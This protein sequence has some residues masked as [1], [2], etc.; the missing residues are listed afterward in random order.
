MTRARIVIP[1]AFAAPLLAAPVLLAASAA[2]QPLDGSFR[3]MYVCQKMQASPDILRAPLDLVVHGEKVEFARPLFN[4]N[5]TR[6]VGSEMASGSVDPDGKMHLTSGWTNRGVTFQ[7]DYTGTLSP[8]GGTFTGTQN[9]H[10][11]NGISGSRTCTAAL[12]QTASAE[13]APNSAEQA[14]PKQ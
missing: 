13:Q 1:I 8:T 11:A 4:W 7:A 5:G 3:G 6:V 14:P 12:V 10:A 2:A 9:W